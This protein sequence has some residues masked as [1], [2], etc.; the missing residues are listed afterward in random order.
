MLVRY[1]VGDEWANKGEMSVTTSW[2]IKANLVPI[3]VD[4]VEVIVELTPSAVM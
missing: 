3:V 4:V 1:T 2:D